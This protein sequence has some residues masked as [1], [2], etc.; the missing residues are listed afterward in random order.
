[1]ALHLAEEE[2]AELWLLGRDERALVETAEATKARGGTAHHLCGD[3][4]DRAWLYRQASSLDGLDGLVHAAALGLETPFSDP[5]SDE[6]FDT[7]IA[8]DL[9]GAW[10]VARAFV[11]KM[12]K[13]SRV[14]FV[15][16]V[17]GRFGVP[18]MAAYCAAKHGLLGLTKALAL[19]LLPKGIVVN[20]VAPGWMDTDMAASRVKEM[21][22]AMRVE[23]VE[24]RRRA[25]KQVPMQ[26]FFKTEEIAKGIA[27]M[28]SPENTTQVGQC[29]NLDGGVMQD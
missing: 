21:A 5:K 8:V 16:S 27:W 22:S 14:V 17:L 11:P 28:L 4:R 25:E 2:C 12:S 26:R 18:G 1:V 29:L 10:N 6:G 24:A 23:E 3:I 19:E 7:M 9:T 15:A 13:G 20:A